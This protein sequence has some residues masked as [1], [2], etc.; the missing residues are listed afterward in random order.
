LK[1]PAKQGKHKKQEPLATINM[2][3]VGQED[4]QD[5]SVNKALMKAQKALKTEEDSKLVTLDHHMSAYDETL[6]SLNSI[7]LKAP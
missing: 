2:N 6:I 3:I 1:K 5:Q 7:A 4:E